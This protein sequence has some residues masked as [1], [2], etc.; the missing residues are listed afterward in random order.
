MTAIATGTAYTAWRLYDTW[1]GRS[2]APITDKTDEVTKEQTPLKSSIETGE[3][4]SEIP[5]GKPSSVPP[6][7]SENADSSA[8][9]G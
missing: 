8:K 2:T 5:C 3:A 1:N 9:L 6:V 7:E 4:H